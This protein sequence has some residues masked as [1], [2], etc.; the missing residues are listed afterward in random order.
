MSTLALIFLEK[1]LNLMIKNSLELSKNIKF[2]KRVI[3]QKSTETRKKIYFG[4]WL[5]I[6][7]MELNAAMV[8]K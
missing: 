8:I 3:D 1:I 7:K 2:Y 5:I 4:N 6:L